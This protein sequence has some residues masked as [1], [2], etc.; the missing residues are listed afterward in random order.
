MER[1]LQHHRQT[2]L[3]SSLP[4]LQSLEN[5]GYD[6]AIM[7]LA[8]AVANQASL[9]R[10]VER[11]RP[12]LPSI[13]F[14]LLFN[15]LLNLLNVRDE[16]ELPDFWFSLALATKK[17]EFGVVRQALEAYSKSPQAFIPQVPIPTPKLASNLTTVTLVADH[18]DDL[19]TGLQPFVVMDGTEEFRLASLK[20]AQSYMVLTEQQ[21]S[22]KLS[23]LAQLDVPKELR[24]HPTNFY[25]LGKSL[26]LYGNLLGTV[27]G[28]AH[29]ITT[30]YRTFW[31]AFIGRQREEMHYEIDDRRFIKPVHILRNVQLITV[32]WFQIKQDGDTPPAPPFQ[33]IL[34]RIGLATYTIPTLPAAL[35]QLIAPKLG[36]GETGPRRR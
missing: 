17:Q 10:D 8:N 31:K 3:Y 5:L 35:Y 15:T 28:N 14:Q 20:I 4:A 18:D 16:A 6:P 24:A 21:L 34:A 19:K 9:A 11:D 12:T 30:T 36:T 32:Q 13:K 26:G 27:L 25:G 7:Y 22:L 29:P 1:D 23:D 33:D 2:I